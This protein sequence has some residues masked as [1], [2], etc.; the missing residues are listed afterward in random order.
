MYIPNTQLDKI[1]QIQT[2]KVQ[3]PAKK[4][5]IPSSSQSDSLTVSSQAMEMQKAIQYVTGLPDMRDDKVQELRAQ[6]GEG[7]YKISDADLA[8]AI[9]AASVQGRNE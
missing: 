5:S 2:A 9:F 7:S 4:T 3:R 8:S 1:F 6:V